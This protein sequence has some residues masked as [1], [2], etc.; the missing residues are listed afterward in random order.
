MF[1][2]ELLTLIGLGNSKVLEEVDV[3]DD[4]EDDIAV[5]VHNIALPPNSWKKTFMKS[6]SRE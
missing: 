1:P 3:G 5:V 2:F 4:D 6:S